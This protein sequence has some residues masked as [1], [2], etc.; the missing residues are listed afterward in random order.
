MSIG[1][2]KSEQA[3][4]LCTSI[5]SCNVKIVMILIRLSMEML[6]RTMKAKEE[7]NLPFVAALVYLSAWDIAGTPPIKRSVTGISKIFKG[8]INFKLGFACGYR[9]WQ[10]DKLHIR[11]KR[12]KQRT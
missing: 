5:L 2:V 9:G 1:R 10:E 4:A 12:L 7:E 8:S 6:L 3:K 11:L